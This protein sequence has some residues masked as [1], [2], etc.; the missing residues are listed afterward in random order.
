MA[1]NALCNG[2]PNP[3]ERVLEFVGRCVSIVE[4]SKQRAMLKRVVLESLNEQGVPALDRAARLKAVFAELDAAD[5]A[6]AAAQA[7]AEAV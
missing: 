5:E 2:T 7:P 4:G 1:L 6:A 3:R